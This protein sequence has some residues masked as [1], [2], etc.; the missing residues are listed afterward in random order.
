MADD[1]N[2][3]A[4]DE[5]KHSAE[6]QRRHAADA[7]QKRIAQAEEDRKKQAQAEQDRK[8]EVSQ[9]ALVPNAEGNVIV[10]AIMGPYRGQHLTMTEADGQAAIN[11]HWARD[12]TEAL[13][14][15]EALDDEH[16]KEAVDAA[17]AWAQT[18]WDAAQ[19]VEDETPP[20]PEGGEGE[21]E[22][23]IAARRRAMTPEAPTGGYTTRAT[24]TPAPTPRPAP[25][26]QPKK[27]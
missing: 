12:P 18:Q 2:K 24:P 3:R 7:E 23:G 21:G 1:D 17:H 15:H 4:D 5:R 26:H 8:K 14:E 20:P 9:R 6:E 22:G 16:R 27:P 25:T 11:D 19:G 13:Y 10:E